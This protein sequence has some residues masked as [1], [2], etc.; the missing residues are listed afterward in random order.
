MFSPKCASCPNFLPQPFW[1]SSVYILS[2]PEFS[3]QPSQ[4]KPQSCLPNCRQIRTSENNAIELEI[5]FQ[6]KNCNGM[7]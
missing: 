1:C 5:K 7:E 4:T 6:R 2:I 3:S